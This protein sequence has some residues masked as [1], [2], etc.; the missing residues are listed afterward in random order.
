MTEYRT[1]TILVIDDDQ[2]LARAITTR[3]GSLGYACITASTGEQG[4]AQFNKA[5][6]D[7][8]IS[9]LNMPEGDGLALAESIRRTSEVPIVFITGYRDHYKRRLRTIP[10][11]TTLR[12]P[13]DGQLL[14]ELVTAALHENPVSPFVSKP[15][16][17][18]PAWE[19]A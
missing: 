5:S 13:F 11:V 17:P 19:A 18:Q 14:G 4:L 9:D 16:D 3:L 10:N 7:L 15:T 12:K 1:R 2:E 8:V 6:I